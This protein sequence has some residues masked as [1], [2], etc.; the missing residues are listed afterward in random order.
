M[1]H[2]GNDSNFTELMRDVPFAIVDFYG[3][4]CGSCVVLEPIFNEASN[5]YGMLKFIKVNCTFNPEVEKQYGVR[6]YPTMKFFRY[7]KEVFETAGWMER[8]KLDEYIA[9]LLYEYPIPER[10]G[11]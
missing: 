1:V 10:E 7:G 5:D 2:I 9:S 4:Y 3:E 8:E 6:G 11:E